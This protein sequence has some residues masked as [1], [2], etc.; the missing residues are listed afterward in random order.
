MRPARE[1]GRGKGVVNPSPAVSHAPAWNLRAASSSSSSL[2]SSLSVPLIRGIISPSLPLSLSLSRPIPTDVRLLCDQNAA[3]LVRRPL[4]YKGLIDPIDPTKCS[5]CHRKKGAA[6]ARPAEILDPACQGSE[7]IDTRIGGGFAGV[8]RVESASP[9][10][11]LRSCDTIAS[12]ASRI[13]RLRAHMPLVIGSDS[14]ERNRVLIQRNLTRLSRHTT[15]RASLLRPF[16]PSLARQRAAP[17]HWI[18]LFPLLI[19]RAAELSRGE[20]FTVRL[21]ERGNLPVGSAL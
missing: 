10:R 9:R 2:S 21:T 1:R 16:S 14:I 6:R 8:L 5:S 18:A 11:F 15:H 17:V 19:K 13:L 7:F 4:N 20:D 12:H 3:P